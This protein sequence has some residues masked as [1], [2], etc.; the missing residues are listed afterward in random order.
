M[1]VKGIVSHFYNF[2]IHCVLKWWYEAKKRRIFLSN[3]IDLRRLPTQ[4][5]I[6]NEIYNTFTNSQYMGFQMHI[7]VP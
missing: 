5:P 1:S 4:F 6:K 2:L 7:P 3:E